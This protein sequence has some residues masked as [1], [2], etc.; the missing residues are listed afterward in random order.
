DRGAEYNGG[1]IIVNGTQTNQITNQMM[2]GG[3]GGMGGKQP[4]NNGNSNGQY[5]GDT[6]APGSV[7]PPDQEDHN[8]NSRPGRH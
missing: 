3:F 5:P 1:T 4:G 7:M 6:E 2:G 8:G